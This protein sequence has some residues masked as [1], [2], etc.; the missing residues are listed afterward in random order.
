MKFNLDKTDYILYPESIYKRKVKSALLVGVYWI[1]CLFWFGVALF[2]IVV[3]HKYVYGL[4]TGV[5]Q[6]L[7]LFL[8]TLW[9]ED[10]IN[11]H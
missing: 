6:V 2:D 1:W 7:C 10:S 3:L 5:I 4:V 8:A 9:I 11:D